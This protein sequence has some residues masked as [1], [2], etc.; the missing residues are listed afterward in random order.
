[1]DYQW[2]PGHMTKARRRMQENLKLVD[3]VIELT[4]ARAVMSG[5]NP[6]IDALAQG[7]ARILVLT[8]ADLADEAGNQAWLEW[9]RSKKLCAAAIN[10]RTGSVMRQIKP[11]ILQACAEKIERDR[12]RGIVNR[13]I[14]AMIAGIPNVGKSTFINSFAGRSSAKTGNKPGVTRGEQW[15]RPDRSVELLDTPGLL[16]PKFEDQEVGRRLALTGTIRDELLDP[17][18]L[19]EYL[20]TYLMA[21]YPGTLEKRYAI[22][23]Q[24]DASRVLEDTAKSRALLLAGGEPDQMR[25]ARAVIDDFR[26]GKLGRISLEFPDTK[27]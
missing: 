26:T 8:K 24:A 25:A 13:P 5:R 21:Q 12:K 27:G 15:I 14:R 4:D 10:A 3:L 9:F 20:I 17:G 6:D 22:R 23:E 19:S 18:E 2:Y 1:M 7:K 16:W 11:L